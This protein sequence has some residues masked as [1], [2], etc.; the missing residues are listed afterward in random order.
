MKRKQI[1][2][3]LENLRHRMIEMEANIAGHSK[4]EIRLMRLVR[5]PGQNARAGKASSLARVIP[6]YVEGKTP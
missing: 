3:E 5:F 2:Q 1:L 4:S 6:H